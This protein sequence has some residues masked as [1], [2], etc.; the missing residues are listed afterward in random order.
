MKIFGPDLTGEERF[1]MT[2][3]DT[4]GSG[5]LNSHQREK[6]EVLLNSTLRDLRSKKTPLKT[7]VVLSNPP[8]C[9]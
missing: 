6:S 5:T 2:C 1:L 3:P 4:S 9:L 8:P 7:I